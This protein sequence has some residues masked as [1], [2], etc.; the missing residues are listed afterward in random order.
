[1]E[2]VFRVQ[3]ARFENVDCDIYMNDREAYMTREQ[4]GL[5]L[6]YPDPRIAIAKIHHRHRERLDRYSV[7]TKLVSTDGKSYPTVVYPR[8]GIMEICRWSNKPRA[9]AFMD[10]VWSVMDALVTH[11]ARLQS[12]RQRYG[13]VNAAARLLLRALQEADVEPKARLAALER[14]YQNAGVSILPEGLAL[15]VAAGCTAGLPMPEEKP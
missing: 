2:E 4:I 9:D 11:S 5:A 8:R 15:E 12:K 14:L 1:M 3:S 13:D 6:G 7:V 10:F